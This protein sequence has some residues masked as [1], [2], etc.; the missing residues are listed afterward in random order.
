MSAQMMKVRCGGRADQVSHLG[1]QNRPLL[2]ELLAALS[3]GNEGSSLLHSCVQV[4]VLSGEDGS[5][6]WSSNLGV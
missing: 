2:D 5:N 1:V 6:S 4:V 3:A